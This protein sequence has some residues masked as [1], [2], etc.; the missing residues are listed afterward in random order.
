MFY[1]GPF[2]ATMSDN[3]ILSQA[4]KD[5]QDLKEY[6]N[7]HQRKGLVLLDR[8][9][10]HT[11]QVFEKLSIHAKFKIPGWTG[12]PPPSLLL[13]LSLSILT[14]KQI[15]VESFLQRTFRNNTI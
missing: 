6:L 12:Q 3:D 13:S 5:S 9:F 1:Y 2:G 8:G 14:L 11:D 7:L 10:N 4:I 15:K